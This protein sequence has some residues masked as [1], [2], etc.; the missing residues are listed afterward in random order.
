MTY[1]ELKKK[2]AGELLEIGIPDA[3][4]DV[5]IMLSTA[6]G[7]SDSMLFAY[8]FDEVPEEVLERFSVMLERRKKHEPLQYILGFQEFMGLQF[9]VTP[10][11]LIPRQDTE[12][13]AE[14]GIEAAGHAISLRKKSLQKECENAE[15]VRILDLC[16]GSGCVAVSVA[17]GADRILAE[18]EDC[19]YKGKVCVSVTAAD[20][21]EAAVKVA[22]KNA[23]INKTERVAVSFK[24]SDLFS[25]TEGK[26]DVITANPPYVKASSIEILMPEIN[27]YE[28]WL[29]LDGGADGLVFYRR[30][31]AEAPGYLKNGG[32]L[33]MEMDDDQGPAVADMLKNRGFCNVAVYRDLTGADRVA[34]GEWEG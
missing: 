5:R 3:E 8:I 17:D 29:A 10:D 22:E 34:Y 18:Y 14:K 27:R 23:E 31:V 16:T 20:I 15:P 33:I 32:R 12:L 21:S 4:T 6:S 30:I 9:L 24:V 13:L 25:E 26:F 28:P 2:S 7:L 19:G 11:V 1:F